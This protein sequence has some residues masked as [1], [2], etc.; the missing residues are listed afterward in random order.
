MFRLVFV[1]N[2]FVCFSSHLVFYLSRSSLIDILV[3]AHWVLLQELQ[4]LLWCG[5]WCAGSRTLAF[6]SRTRSPSVEKAPPHALLCQYLQDREKKHD[7]A[8]WIHIKGSMRHWNWIFHWLWYLPLR[9]RLFILKFKGAKGLE[10]T[11]FPPGEIKNNKQNK[12]NKYI[13]FCS[14]HSSCNGSLHKANTEYE[15]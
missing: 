15:T 2:V 14:G 12:I 5:L 11:I 4:C 1:S 7:T 6:P 10:D 8:F 3:S 13:F 9:F